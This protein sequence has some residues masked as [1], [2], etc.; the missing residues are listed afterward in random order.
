MRIPTGRLHANSENESER[1]PVTTMTAQR[2]R[3]GVTLLFV[4]AMLVLAG[5]S[6]KTA[7]VAPK[8][9]K[10]P[11]V[12]PKTAKG[13]AM[14]AVSSLSTTAPDAKLLLG[15]TVAATP[16]TES[17]VWQF[18]LGSPKTS[19]VYSV[20]VNG[21]IVQTQK[22]GK[23]K[24]KSDEWA[25]IP[26]LNAWKI[27]SDVARLNAVGLNPNTARAAYFSSFVTYVSS[28][29]SRTATSIP[30]KWVIQF[31]PAYQ[32]KAPT[33]TIMVDMGTGAATF[34]MPVRGKK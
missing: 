4:L 12:D 14:W 1:T 2:L 7:A 8:T 29:A 30:M 11:S 10:W 9:I 16:T 3:I 18:L 34:A 5:C 13:A 26:S 20:L 25:K 17:P 23:V 6:P 32:A 19:M 33:S 21:R 15:Q 31:D 22:F 24:M 28:A 27:D